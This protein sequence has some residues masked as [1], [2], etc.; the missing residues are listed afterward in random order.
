[1]RRNDGAPVS[2]VENL[3][4]IKIRPWKWDARSAIKSSK[5]MPSVRTIIIY[6]MHAILKKE[7]NPS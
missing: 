2:S 5:V 1:M 3:W 4:Y 7:F 6:V